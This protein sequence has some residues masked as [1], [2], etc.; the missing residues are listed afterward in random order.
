MKRLF[1][2]CFKNIKYITM[3]YVFALLVINLF[4]VIRGDDFHFHMMRLNAVADEFR[5]NG[6]SAYP[7]RIYSTVLDGYGYAS[8]MFYSDIFMQPFALLTFLGISVLSAYRLMKA[9]VLLAAYFICIKISKD[10][11]NNR[12]HADIF[13][14]VYM[15]N[16]TIYGN[17]VGSAIG[18]S[19]AVV[20]VPLAIAGLYMILYKNKKYDWIYLGVGVAGLLFSNVLDCIIGVAVLAVIFVFNI[21]NLDKKKF[22]KI[23]QSVILFLGL[24][25]WFILPM[26]EQM[27]SQEFFVTSKR[28]SEEKNDLSR[29]TVPFFG[30]FMPAK[31]YRKLQTIFNFDSPAA[32][33][34]MSGL[35]V[36]IFV[37]VVSIKRYKRN[38]NDKF[39]ISILSILIFFIWFQTKWFPFKLVKSITGVIQFPYRV[40]IVMTFILSFLCVKLFEDYQNKKIV[41]LVLFA[42]IYFISLSFVSSAGVGIAKAVLRGEE[43]MDYSYT[44]SDIMG[45]EYLPEKLMTDDFEYNKEFLDAHKDK[46]VCSN[47]EANVEL[48]RL[49]KYAEVRFENNNT[50]SRFEVPIIMYKGYEAVYA[51]SGESLAISS[52]ENGLISFVSER[53]DATVQIRYRGTLVQNISDTVS[54]LFCVLLLVYAVIISGKKKQNS[55][56]RMIP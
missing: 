16:A 36:Y 22:S 38:Y 27:N 11:F 2:L 26:L 37:A 40:G 49:K 24:T 45:A 35:L 29:F 46:V 34:Y 47:N 1:E 20:F 52:S 21:R 15:I 42:S 30:L 9:C 44:M 51:D 43:Y 55:I 14:A 18:R 32:I 31:Y 53:S 4:F 39:I 25:F 17:L 12:E 6:F 13:V 3:I 56:Y 5:T 48:R 28:I 23:V 54:M 19:F 8:P 7:I 10:M 50:V 41:V 33:A